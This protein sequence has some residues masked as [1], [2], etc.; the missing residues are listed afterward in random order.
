MAIFETKSEYVDA[1][2][3]LFNGVIYDVSEDR[4]NEEVM[5]LTDQMI[6]ELSK[7]SEVL[8]SSGF[9]IIYNSIA[10][11]GPKGYLVS[12]IATANLT[13]L[14]QC[15]FDEAVEAD[16]LEKAA[17]ILASA[18]EFG[19]SVKESISQGKL[20]KKAFTTNA[21]TTLVGEFLTINRPQV[22]KIF[23]EWTKKLTGNRRFLVGLNAARLKYRSPIE[24]ALMGL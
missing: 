24:L 9:D 19:I 10:N 18:A 3:I 14:F 22:K 21:L 13:K 15:A 23:T 12:E 1:I 8:A 16:K 6:I 20:P 2:N 4:I 5:R 11:L 17:E 7:P